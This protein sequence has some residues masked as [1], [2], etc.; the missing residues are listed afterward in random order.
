MNDDEIQ[1]LWKPFGLLFAYWR[2]CTKEAQRERA[3]ARAQERER[4]RNLPPSP[5][6]EPDPAREE[7]LRRQRVGLEITK[8][9][10]LDEPIRL[11][12]RQRRRKD[13]SVS[14]PESAAEDNNTV[15]AGSS[16]AAVVQEQR[17]DDALE[18]TPLTEVETISSESRLPLSVDTSIR[19]GMTDGSNTSCIPVPDEGRHS[20][21]PLVEQRI[22][23]K[24]F[25]KDVLGKYLK[26]SEE[27]NRKNAARS[28]SA[29]ATREQRRHDALENAPVTDTG[30]VSPESK[31]PLQVAGEVSGGPVHDSAHAGSTAKDEGTQGQRPGVEQRSRPKYFLKDVF[32][33]YLKNTGE[34]DPHK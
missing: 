9:D 14:L 20:R 8:P 34:R 10:W 31:P 26:T 22:R 29:A 33:K 28:S 4:L 13:M 17:K 30:S 23:P 5:P 11:H 21:R 32:G 16:S 6:P 27:I 25:L 3:I 19:E 24:Y 7:E 2:Y 12:K 18:K 1:N 15:G